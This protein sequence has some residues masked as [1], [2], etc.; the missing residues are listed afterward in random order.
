M[1]RRDRPAQA[2]HGHQG[3]RARRLGEISRPVVE[4]GHGRT[5]G[6]IV[7]VA[8]LDR[9]SMPLALSLAAPERSRSAYLSDLP[10]WSAHCDPAPSA[11]EYGLRGSLVS[12]LAVLY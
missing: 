3:G 11:A 2:R 6:R 4:T 5:L 12:I 8:S 7:V 10:P 9:R 1:P